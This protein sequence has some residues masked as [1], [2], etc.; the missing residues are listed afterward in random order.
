[1]AST[2]QADLTEN[3][4]EITKDSKGVDNPA[5]NNKRCLA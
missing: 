4:G 2:S 5:F 3:G 1:M